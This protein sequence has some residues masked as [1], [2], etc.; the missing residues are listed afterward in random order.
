MSI[1]WTQRR[2]GCDAYLMG[3]MV[4]SLFSGVAMTPL[5]LSEL[6]DPSHDWKTWRGFYGDVLPY[7]QDA[8]ARAC[9]LFDGH[10]PERYRSD[11][12]EIV[13]QLCNPD[14]TLRG[15]PLNRAM[16]FGNPYSLERYVARFN[17]LASRAE[18]E[19]AVAKA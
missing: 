11:L 13:L 9:R 5:L 10:V 17:L 3:S 6:R 7:L 18:Y 4:V 16:T 15:H 12:S 2:L 14:P 1:D 19:F 8:F